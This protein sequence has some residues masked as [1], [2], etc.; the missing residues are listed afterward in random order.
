MVSSWWFPIVVLSSAWLAHLL[1]SWF[2]NIR[3]C[4]KSGIPFVVIPFAPHSIAAQLLAPIWMPLLSY[5]P[6]PVRGQW[7]VFMKTDMLWGELYAPFRLMG[8]DTVLTCS[9]MSIVLWTCAADVNNQITER[10]NDFIKPTQNY[11]IIDIYGK[12]AIS[13]EGQLWKKH[14][15]VIGPPFNEKNNQMVWSESIYQVERVLANLL[16]SKLSSKSIEDVQDLSS[17][18]SLSIISQA[19]YG[20]RM[21]SG[22]F[23]TDGKESEPIDERAKIKNEWVKGNIHGHKMSYADA[24]LAVSTHVFWLFVFPRP[25]LRVLPFKTAR[26]AYSAF[27]EWGQYM[28]E[29]IEAKRKEIDAIENTEPPQNSDLLSALVNNVG[30][31]RAFVKDQTT[32][33]GSIGI[34]GFSEDELMGNTFMLIVAGHETTAGTLHICLILLAMHVTSQRRLQHDIDSL[35]GN[36]DP[37]DWDFDRDFSKASGTMVGAVL[38]EVLRWGCP[39]LAIPKWTLTEQALNV[40]G[41][42]CTVPKNTLIS[43]HVAAAH[44]NPNQ[45]PHSKP[46]GCDKLEYEHSNTDDLGEFNPQRWLLEQS[47]T[48]ARSIGSAAGTQSQCDEESI[49]DVADVAATL[50]RPIKGAYIPFSMGSRACKGRRF[51]QVEVIAIL[52][53]I[54][55]KY[56]LELAVDEWASDKEVEPMGDDLKMELWLKAKNSAKQKLRN[57]M[58]FLMTNRMEGAHVPIRFVKR[59]SERFAVD[60]CG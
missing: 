57:N 48:G 58:R 18:I 6:T 36:R 2:I 29:M 59:G 10:R 56:S 51:S 34:D 39:V 19:G 20:I 21:D 41:A 5:L 25:L 22:R 37:S 1:H 45:W 47:E 7:C 26:L 35:F 16:Q 27:H 33:S 24:L 40:N 52:S 15:K 4:Q 38:N 28:R 31:P 23:E 55:Q 9:P 42:A 17:R 43:L 13:V 32:N 44:R 30:D 11:S 46:S 60:M 53:V 50:I 12:S 8:S 14:S 3:A 54:F 49:S